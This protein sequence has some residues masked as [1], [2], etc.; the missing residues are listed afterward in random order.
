MRSLSMGLICLVPSI[1]FADNG[2]QVAAI[3]PPPPASS[4]VAPAPAPAP[5]PETGTHLRNG[6]SISAGEEVGSGPSSGLTGQLYGVDWRI[7]AHMAGPL[8]VYA[9]THLSLGTAKIGGASG[10][11][12]N[13][14]VAL[15]GE[16]ELPARTFIAAGGGYGVLNN[17]SGPLAQARVGWYPF[18]HDSSVARRLDVALDARF[19]FAGDQ[20]GTVSQ[21]ALTLGY[22]RF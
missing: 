2:A 9:D 11:T 18:E 7:G 13:F 5:V 20:V 10:A 22:D 8:S 14:A 12:G 16:Y 1:A 3:E 15:I 21:I 4:A 19:Y 6:F 17:P